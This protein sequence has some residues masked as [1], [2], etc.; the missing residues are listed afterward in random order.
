MEK[1]LVTGANG[2]LGACIFEKLSA[3]KTKSVEKLQGRLEEIKPCSLLYDVVIHSAGAL[4][5]RKGEQEKVNSE[6]TKSL[7]N[8]LI[9][10]TKFV[11]ISSKSIYGTKSEGTI[12]EQV[13]PCPDD[14]YG[15]SK[16]KGEIAILESGL[17]YIIIRSS[18]LFGLG[19]N[20]LGPAFPS[21]AMQQ[22]YQGNDINLYI[23]DE[24]E[25]YLYVNDLASVIPKLIRIPES[26]N[27][28]F[29]AS[30]PKQSIVGLINTMEHY[31]KINASNIGDIHKTP[32]EPINKFYLDSSKLKNTIGEN[33]Y[34]PNEVIIKR[35]VEYLC[36]RYSS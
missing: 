3:D 32:K 12:T 27:N 22:L 13:S 15:I 2:Y 19:V 1:V 4:R 36:S 11:Y 7:I 33:I 25:E 10:G 9:E 26:W 23:P 28:I 30:G 14:D 35:M 21:I 20:N 31:L 29:N 18:T 24:L 16:Y 34:T 6:G 8:G 17:P 5:Y